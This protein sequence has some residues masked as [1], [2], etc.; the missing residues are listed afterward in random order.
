MPGVQGKGQGD[1]LRA[2][3]ICAWCRRDMGRGETYDGSPTH[4]IC[5][6]CLKAQLAELDRV[7]GSPELRDRWTN[8]GEFGPAGRGGCN[9][10]LLLVCIIALVVSMAAVTGALY[11]VTAWFGR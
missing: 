8:Q 7:E 6:K 9:I 5:P 11:A 3:R 1:T 4:G 10:P 2:R